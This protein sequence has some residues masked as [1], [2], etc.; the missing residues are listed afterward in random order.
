MQI[1]NPPA[2][3]IAAL[4]DKSRPIRTFWLLSAAPLFAAVPALAAEEQSDGASAGSDSGII[5]LG[6]RVE[7]VFAGIRPEDELNEADIAAYGAD[8]V[9][10]LL[11]ILDEELSGSDGAPVVLIED[12]DP[13]A[14]VESRHP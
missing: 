7:P 3:A 2:G 5:V 12:H 4:R 1:D 13:G 10:D 6:Q 14:P 8:N 9:G 11:D